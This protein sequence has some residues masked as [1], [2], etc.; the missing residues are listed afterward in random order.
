MSI[1]EA[2]HRIQIVQGLDGNVNA[3]KPR[4]SRELWWK[5]IAK[6]MAR[7]VSPTG[8]SLDYLNTNSKTS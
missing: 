2:S 4:K 1:Q 7:L 6:H 5:E 8:K 3:E